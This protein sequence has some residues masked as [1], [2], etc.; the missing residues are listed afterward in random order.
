MTKSSE[1]LI[2]PTIKQLLLICAVKYPPLVAACV[3][4]CSNSCSGLG[5]YRIK[6]D[7][8]QEEII[9]LGLGAQVPLFVL[10]FL[11]SFYSL[12]LSMKIFNF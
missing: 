10:N 4:L 3:L 5:T 8:Y 2:N 1:R 9:Y 7:G 11:I 6:T 12:P